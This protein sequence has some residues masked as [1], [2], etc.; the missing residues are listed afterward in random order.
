MMDFNITN[1]SKNFDDIMMPNGT[2]NVPK[3]RLLIKYGDNI[4]A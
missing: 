1:P 4:S 3:G 2:F